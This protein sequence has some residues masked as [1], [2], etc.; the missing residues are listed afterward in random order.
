MKLSNMYFKTLREVPAEAV[1][2][3]HIWLLRA[4][5]IK[6]LVSGVYGYMPF[7]Y[8]SIRKIEQIVREEMDN[9][10]G[11]EILMSAVQP[12]ELWQES[13]R[14]FDYGP[15][16]WRLKDRNQ[17]DFCLGPTHEEIFT[18]IVRNDIT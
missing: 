17:R 4:G 3:S 7:G 5:M 1:I 10:G 16:L 6:K 8:R 11:Q 9:I 14:W 13:G 18:D 12:A 2:P 15:E